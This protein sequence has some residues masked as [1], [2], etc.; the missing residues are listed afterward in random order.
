MIVVGAGIGGLTAAHDLA[1]AGHE[2]VVLE[3]SDRIGGKL[4]TAQVAGVSVDV[5]AEAMLARRPEG[6]ALAESL[7]LEIVHP[8]RA[9]S[10]IWT[11]GALRPL[12]RSLMGVPMDLDQL[13]ATGILSPEGLD[14]ARREA[15]LPRDPSSSDVADGIDVTVGSLVDARFG[16][17]VTDQLVEPLLGGVYAGRAREISLRA[18][19]PQLAAMAAAGPLTPQTAAIPPASDAPVFAGIAGGMGRLPA[20]LADG[21]DVRTGRRVSLVGLPNGHRRFEVAMHDR[22]GEQIV[23]EA[24]GVVVAT[25]ARAAWDILP[26]LPWLATDPLRDLDYASV[27]VITLAFRAEDLPLDGTTSGFLVPPREGRFIKASTFSFAKW[28]WVRD[29]GDG[30]LLLRTSVGRAGEIGALDHT[31]AELVARSLADL[32]EAIPAVGEPVDT[33]VQRWPDALPQYRVEHLREIAEL[34]EA[35]ADVPGLAICGAA[36]DGVGIPAVIASAHLAADRLMGR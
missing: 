21:L 29:A 34:R 2:V 8:T 15:S 17:E 23:E 3:G 28:D 7:G 30:V 32:R 20:A 13:E 18:A 14:R 5:G 1:A 16:P 26:E 31:D 4:R 12:P 22:R 19:V 33:H 24:D 10:R 9:T 35:V 27:A 36:Y 6:V 25:P 11:R